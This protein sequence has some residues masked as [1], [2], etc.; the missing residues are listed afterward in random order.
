MIVGTTASELKDSRAKHLL[1]SRPDLNIFC[2][3]FKIVPESWLVDRTN[4]IELPIKNYVLP[5]NVLPNFDSLPKQDL[6][7]CGINRALELI[8]LNQPIYFLWSGGIDSTL[9]LVFFMLVQAKRH[10]LIVVCNKDSI[11]EYSKFYHEHILK[12][13]NLMAS[14]ELIQKIKTVGIDGVVL[15]SEHGDL[16]YG[17]DFGQAMFKMFG[18]S[19]LQERPTRENITKFFKQSNMSDQAADCWYDLFMHSMSTSPRPIETNYDFSWWTGFNWRWQWSKEKFK[20]RTALP[21]NIQTFFSDPNIQKWSVEHQQT[22]IDKLSDFKKLSKEVILEYTKDVEYFNH[23]IKH[24]S[25]TVY[26]NA[27]SYVASDNTNKKFK[28]S[29]FKIIDYYQPTNFISDWIKAQ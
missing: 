3:V 9:A 18:A 6:I 29:D 17:Q 7:T 16:M 20:L 15:S 5:E 27:N 25:A 22:P 12:Q 24:P 26:Y 14:E 10:Q 4:T 19:Y 2:E 21:A 1:E 8:S 13:F 23:K 11:R 28:S